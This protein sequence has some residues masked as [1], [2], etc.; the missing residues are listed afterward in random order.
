[1]S[2]PAAHHLSDP[3]LL[4]QDSVHLTQQLSAL[5]AREA[6][7]MPDTMGVTNV[8]EKHC[9]HIKFDKALVVKLMHLERGFVNK[10]PEHID[11]FGGGLTGVHIVRFVSDD[12]SKLFDDV[13]DADMEQIQDEINNVPA[14]DPSFNISSEAFGHACLWIMHQ[15]MRSKYLTE[16]LKQEGLLRISLYLNYRYLTSILYRF[17]KYPA[18]PETAAATYAALSMRFGL[19]EAGSWGKFLENRSRAIFEKDSIHYNTLLQGGPDYNLVIA[20]NDI[21]GRLKSTMINIYGVF[22]QVH[23]EGAKISKSTDHVELDGE[24]VLKDRVD[25]Q[26][27]YTRYLK[28]TI[29]DEAGFIKDELFE[30]ITKVVHTASPY[31]LKSLLQWFSSNY[32]HVKTDTLQKIVDAVMAHA[33]SYMAEQK[34]ILAKHSD[35]TDMLVKLRGTYT[36]SRQSSPELMALKAQVEDMIEK[37]IKV[38]NESAKASLRTAFCLYLVLRAL[39]KKYY[40]TQ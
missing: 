37:S 25:I 27:T 30:I 7:A 10:R 2:Y 40:S 11:F 22:M 4:E 6:S 17:F 19:K 3:A 16:E 36:S 29:A 31:Q 15:L 39:T 8:F 5:L 33:F 24:M 1:V 12:V 35:P 28:D 32:M 13:L 14:I 21:Q 23:K 18:N 20:L 38:K 26:A 34:G 9:S